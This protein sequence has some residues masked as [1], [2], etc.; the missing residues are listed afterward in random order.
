MTKRYISYG[1]NM[2]IAAM[3]QRAPTARLV[4]ETYLKDFKLVFSGWAFVVPSAGD[5]VPVLMWEI[6]D[7]AE[8]QLDW[9]EGYPSL[10][11]KTMVEVDGQQALVYIMQPEAVGEQVANVPSMN[12]ITAVYDKF[13]PDLV[14]GLPDVFRSV[15]NETSAYQEWFD[16][17]TAA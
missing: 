12:A 3:S 6:D 16:D 4:R 1:T 15:L 13:F 5:H 10:Y 14:E 11:D 17:K 8:Q 9:Y 7:E 2:D